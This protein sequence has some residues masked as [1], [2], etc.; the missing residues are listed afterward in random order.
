MAVTESRGWTGR[1]G[2]G[3]GPAEDGR[4]AGRG[5]VSRSAEAAGRAAR[6]SVDRQTFREELALE[7]PRGRH[8]AASRDVEILPA[9][10]QRLL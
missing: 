10:R 6:M 8:W 7:Q 4:V 9:V 5:V 2:Q 1:A 3:R